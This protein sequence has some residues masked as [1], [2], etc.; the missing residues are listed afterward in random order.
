M[1][2][3]DITVSPIVDASGRP[4]VSAQGGAFKAGQRFDREVAGWTPLLRSAD[5]D[6]L[7]DMN[8]TAARTRDLIRNF[9]LASGAVQTHLDNIVGS[10]LRLVAQPN[11]RLLGISAD[12][13]AKWSRDIESRFWSW[14]YDVD[15]YCDAA[16]RLN[17]AGMQNQGLLS[18][19]SSGEICAVSEW[20][21]NRGSRYATAIKMVSRDRLSNPNGTADAVR[22]RGGVE[23]DANGAPVAHHFREA[24]PSD[25]RFAGA[26]THTWKRIPTFTPWGRR[27]VIHIY[28]QEWAGQTRGLT[29][30]VASLVSSKKLD[31]FEETALEAA[32]INAMYAAVIESDLTGVE[33]ALG[34]DDTATE[35]L[36]AANTFHQGAGIKFD[37]AKIP[38]L[39]PNEKLHFP[40]PG[41]PTD[42]FAPF[43]QAFLRHMAAGWGLSYEQ[44]S[45]DYSQTNYSGARAGLMESWKR[46]MSMREKVVGEFSR[47]VYALWLEEEMDRDPALTPPGAPSFWEAKTAWTR[48]SWIGP[49]KG[50]IDPL[51]EQKAISIKIADGRST[52]QDELSEDGKDWEETLE[53]TARELK[54]KAELEQE[55]GI[56][57]PGADIATAAASSPDTVTP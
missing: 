31:R 53:Q 45:R 50:H 1:G 30:A 4:M 6:I 28:E 54:R 41:Q 39:F 9:G 14:A 12:F 57:F 22:L 10:G 11:Y 21:P 29:R 37:G 52:M 32:I 2:V 3:K 42:T 17:L 13:A 35:Y 38:H 46:F 8:L 25:S 43:E 15:F 20:L 49:G 40:R 5:A 56:K 36:K 34:G 19:L 33:D 7:P 23:M 44:L 48:C 27:R 24:L 47:Q 51:K 18:F 55:Y 26:Q 16:R